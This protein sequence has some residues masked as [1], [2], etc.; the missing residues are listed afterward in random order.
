MSER[1][2]CQPWL[3]RN[4]QQFSL[5]FHTLPQSQR[6]FKTSTGIT[7]IKTFTIGTSAANFKTKLQESSRTQGQHLDSD[8][9]CG[10]P[11]NEPYSPPSF[12]SLAK[13]DSPSLITLSKLLLLSIYLLFTAQSRAVEPEGG[14]RLDPSPAAPTDS[15]DRRAPS[16]HEQPG[17]GIHTWSLPSHSDR[18]KL[19]Y[20][21]SGAHAAPSPA[22]SR[23]SSAQRAGPSGTPQAAGTPSSRPGTHPAAPLGDGAAPAA[24]HGPGPRTPMAG[25]ETGGAEGGDGAQGGKAGRAWREGRDGAE[26]RDSRRVPAGSLPRPAGAGFCGAAMAEPREELTGNGPSVPAAGNHC[27]AQAGWN[28]R[29]DLAPRAGR[30]L[31]HR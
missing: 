25:A 12:D 23:E 20:D 21:K 5:N 22:V 14:A 3:V 7:S 31:R 1:I 11:P 9:P 24:P 16:L 6:F 28:I 27:R 8:D 4:P 18:N 15:G 19:K 17:K 13:T 2:Q 26:G 10:S 30:T 29:D